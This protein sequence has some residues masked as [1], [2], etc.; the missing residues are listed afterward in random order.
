MLQYNRAELGPAECGGTKPNALHELAFLL[1]PPFHLLIETELGD[2]R[3]KDPITEGNI[4]LSLTI[5]DTFS[6]N[7]LVLFTYVL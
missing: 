4:T 5:N 7:T 2:T 3:K 1:L 6:I